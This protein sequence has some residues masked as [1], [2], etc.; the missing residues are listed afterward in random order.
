MSSTGEQEKI[1]P[2]IQKTIEQIESEKM[3]AFMIEYNMI[4]DK[5]GCEIFAQPTWVSTN[6]GSF[7]LSIKVFVDKS[8]PR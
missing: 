1:V 6:H 8:L 7:E 3:Q 5:Y 4:C 2:I